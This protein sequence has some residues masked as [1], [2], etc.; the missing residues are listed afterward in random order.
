MNRKRSLGRNVS[1]ANGHG[2]KQII[3]IKNKN[4]PFSKFKKDCD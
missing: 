2:A 3:G 4:F 1:I